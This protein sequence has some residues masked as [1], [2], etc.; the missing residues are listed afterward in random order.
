MLNFG[1]IRNFTVVSFNASALR[2]GVFGM[3]SG[4]WHLLKTSEKK[5][6]GAKDAAT[7][8]REL[9]RELNGNSDLI[10]LTGTVP[11]GVFFNLDAVALPHRE[12]RDALFMELP[13]RMP[14][15]PS[16][17]VLQFMPV[18]GT[19]ADGM[20]ELHVYAAEQK[21][22]DTVAATLH[23]D[24][25][26]ADE[27]IHPL[28]TVFRNDPAVFLPET[29][30]GFY[31]ADRKFHRADGAEKLLEASLAKWRGIMDDLFTAE[32]AIT[33]FSGFLPVF[34]AARCVI[35]GKFQRHRRELQFLPPELH[36]VR[37][38]RQLRLTA[39]LAASLLVAL[40]W[41]CGRERWRDFSSYRAVVAETRE[42]QAKTDSMQ[43]TLKRTAREQKDIAKVLNSNFGEGDVI[44]Q[45]AAF[46]KLL[47]QDVMVTDFRWSE[48]GIDLVL[49]SESENLDLPGVLKPLSRWKV[50]DLQQRQGRMSATTT[51]TAKLIP[52]DQAAAKTKSA[53]SA[54]SA[55]GN[56]R[57]RK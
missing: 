13:R 42:L 25:I 47:P 43:G 32:E 11:G 16:E 8:W 9:W 7:P 23:R 49:Q 6:A 12:Q 39:I 46:S 22:L 44:E 38:R 52:A 56:R 29:D 35:S 51:V 18:S 50:A 4:H 55:K 45:L 21:Q 3:R 28:V 30:P 19:D 53:K 17:P 36:P 24:R 15:P 54:K 14:R 48:S 26:R 41:S 37:F 34:L 57:K 31:F 1:E 20:A 2:G 10:L 40:L 33:D 5:L 27:L